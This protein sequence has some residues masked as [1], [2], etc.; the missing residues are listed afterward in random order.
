MSLKFINILK[1]ESI[2]DNKKDKLIKKLKLNLLDIFPNTDLNL[3]LSSFYDDYSNNDTIKY[4]E[5]FEDYGPRIHSINKQQFFN[6]VNS[7]DMN[8]YLS[9]ILE[10]PIIKKIISKIKNDGTIT[11]NR[12]ISVDENWFDQLKN[13]K[14]KRLGIYWSWDEGQS[15]YGEN[16]NYEVELIGDIEEKYINWSQTILQNIMYE[17]TENEITLFKNTPIKLNKINYRKKTSDSYLE[18]NPKYF[19]NHTFYS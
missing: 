18:L 9:T 3:F 2:I 17:D 8:Q 19:I 7:S 16:K 10:K 14:I 4:F 6:I 11:I 13:N 12:S 15:I 5:D 1:E